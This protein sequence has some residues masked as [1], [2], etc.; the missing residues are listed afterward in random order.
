M[1]QAAADDPRARSMKFDDE[2]NGCSLIRFVSSH[3]VGHTLG[4]LHNMGK[5]QPNA[6]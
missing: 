5:Q 4:L 1:I 6:C 2:L 3:E